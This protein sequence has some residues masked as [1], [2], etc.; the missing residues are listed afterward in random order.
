M[1]KH[2][3]ELPQRMTR[4]RLP[5]QVVWGRHDAIVPVE[6]GYWCQQAIP[7]AQLHVFDHCGHAPHVEKPDAFFATVLP[8][9]TQEPERHGAGAGVA[10][11]VNPAPAPTRPCA[12]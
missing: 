7:H 5:T 2:N 9:L 4:L 8:F 10:P 11:R 1:H 12:A 3:P 6:H